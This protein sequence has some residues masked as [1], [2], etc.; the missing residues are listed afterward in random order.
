MASSVSGM[1]AASG[2][3]E[4]QLHNALLAGGDFGFSA[5]KRAVFHVSHERGVC[6]GGGIDASARGEN[7]RRQLNGV[8]KVAGNLSERRDEQI[9]E[10]MALERV[11][12]RKRWA[13]SWPAGLLLR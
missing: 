8:G 2:R 4:L 11:A 1:A 6:C 12:A 3:I 5:N 7:L 13:K 10:V 9:A